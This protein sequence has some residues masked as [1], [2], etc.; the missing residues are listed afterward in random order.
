MSPEQVASGTV[1]HRA[2]LYALAVICYRAL[3]G[4]PAFTGDSISE[5]LYKVV[6]TMPPRPTAASRQLDEDVDRVLALGMAKLAVDRF[7]SASELADALDAA[8]RHELS[9][10][11]RARAAR[12][13]TAH[14]WAES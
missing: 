13:M 5:L 11:L 7:D 4:R 1:D 10:A 3:T 14:P 6:H 2:D 8:S 12:V 9:D